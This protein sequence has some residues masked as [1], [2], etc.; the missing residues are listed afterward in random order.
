MISDDEACLRGNPFSD[1]SQDEV[2]KHEMISER[3]R[4]LMYQS[5]EN[6]MSRPRCPGWGW[7]PSSRK[8]SCG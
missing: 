6:D 1:L 3:M 5:A 8:S 4:P 7:P 2:E